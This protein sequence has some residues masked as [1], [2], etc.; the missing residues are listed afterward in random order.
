MFWTNYIL[1]VLVTNLLSDV[2]DRNN[3]D[4]CEL[5]TA[6]QLY[7]TTAKTLKSWWPSWIAGYHDKEMQNAM[8]HFTR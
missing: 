8:S 1:I 3:D 2:D 6:I 5:Y 4:V 7:S